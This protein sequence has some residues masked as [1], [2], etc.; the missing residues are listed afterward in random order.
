MKWLV[1][2]YIGT[3]C[4]CTPDFIWEDSSELITYKSRRY[5]VDAESEVVLTKLLNKHKIYSKQLNKP[6][7]NVHVGNYRLRKPK[8]EEMESGQKLHFVFSILSWRI[9]FSVWQSGIS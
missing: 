2:E 1:S 6:F 8:Q 5:L 7:Q 9:D 4:I 3:C